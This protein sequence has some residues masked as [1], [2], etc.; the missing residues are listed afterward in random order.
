MTISD[1]TRLVARPVPR[2]TRYSVGWPYRW[3][4]YAPDSERHLA[5]F[6]WPLAGPRIPAGCACLLPAHR[7]DPLWFR[8]ASHRVVRVVAVRPNDRREAGCRDGR[9]DRQC[10]LGAAVRALAGDR[11]PG[12][13]AGDG[14]HDYRHS[15]GAGKPQTDPRVA[16]AAGSRRL[17]GPLRSAVGMTLT[18]LGVP[19][20]PG[21]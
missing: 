17:A 8:L 11:S 4:K 13:R 10:H 1:P 7:H 5:G 9:S 2:F 3:R 6:R 21:P 20:V 18:A 16:R 12:E 14:R 19:T 15:V